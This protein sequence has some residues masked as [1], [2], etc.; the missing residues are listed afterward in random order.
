MLLEGGTTGRYGPQVKALRDKIEAELRPKIEA[1][2]RAEIR[3]K[4]N[5]DEPML[6]KKLEDMLSDYN[7][8]MGG[9]G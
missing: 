4:R 5:E 7:R 9:N 2:V 6:L 1:E 8:R 3:R